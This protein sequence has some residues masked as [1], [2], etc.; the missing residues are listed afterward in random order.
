MRPA[1][2][3]RLWIVAAAAAGAFAGFRFWPALT[4]AVIA[5]VLALHQRTGGLS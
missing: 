4:V 1:S 3:A 2:V 5:A